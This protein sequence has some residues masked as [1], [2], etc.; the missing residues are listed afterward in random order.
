M[1]VIGLFISYPA[2]QPVCTGGAVVRSYIE[3]DLSSV[4][5]YDVTNY[6]RYWEME[7]GGEFS[8]YGTIGIIIFYNDARWSG[9]LTSD[10]QVFEGQMMMR[11]NG[12]T[13]KIGNFLKYFAFILILVCVC[14]NFSRTVRFVLGFIATA[15]VCTV[16]IYQYTILWQND[17]TTINK[18]K[19]LLFT[20]FSVICL[21]LLIGSYFWLT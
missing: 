17:R 11:T 2:I 8:R 19:L 5:T 4:H 15:I 13:N 10:T 18:W 21:C 12:K 9:C 20:G 3:D 14:S 6:K 7:A 1:T 16:G